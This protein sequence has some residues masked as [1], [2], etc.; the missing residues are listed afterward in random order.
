MANIDDYLAEDAS[1]EERQAAEQVLMGLDSLRL[2]EKIKRAAAERVRLQRIARQRIAILVILLAMLLAG[3]I[4]WS[5]S[6]A[7]GDTETTSQRTEAPIDETRTATSPVETETPTLEEQIPATEAP[8]EEAPVSQPAE[9][10]PA[11]PPTQNIPIAQ[12]DPSELS[13]L[14][15]PL[16]DAPNTF[17]RG[18]SSTTD[19][20]AQQR[21]NQ[22]WYTS[23][24]LS[25]LELADN[26]SN[27]GEA[28]QDR[29]F[30]QA[31]IRLQRAERRQAAS[32]TLTYLKAYTLLEMGEGTEAARLL[33]ELD[34]I[35]TDWQ[36]QQEW[37]QALAQLLAGELDAAQSLIAQIANQEGHPYQR[38]ALKALEVFG[39]E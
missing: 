25:G 37:Y 9:E 36:P 23:F 13:P 34:D 11:P 2:Q 19:S 28:L 17:L 16:H 18:Q 3:G 39:W 30:T 26:Y 29:N 24:P 10:V 7:K 35:P 14:P 6:Q 5:R 12:S 4:Y 38:E 33:A 27:V 20:A 31:F 15:D 1:A 8:V 22:L 21:L 32:D